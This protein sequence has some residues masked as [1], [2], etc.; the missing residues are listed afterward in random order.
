MDESKNKKLLQLK[1]KR[2]KHMLKAELLR[3]QIELAENDTKLKDLAADEPKAGKRQRVYR[4][5]P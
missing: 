2:A 5:S 1:H 4:P 3:L